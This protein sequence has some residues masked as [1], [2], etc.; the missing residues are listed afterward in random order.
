MA[1]EKKQVF[2]WSPFTVLIAEDDLVNF[3]LLE[4][5]LKRTN[6]NILHAKSGTEA[7]SICNTHKEISIVLMDIQLPEMDG[8]EA[9]QKIKE[10]KPDLP[11]VILTASVFNGEPLHIKNSCYDGFISKPF[12]LNHLIEKIRELLPVN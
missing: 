1:E 4:H 9:A 7:V 3:K 12:N 11:V 8:F 6:I 2:N 5:L 10:E